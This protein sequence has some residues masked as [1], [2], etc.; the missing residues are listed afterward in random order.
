M[1]HAPDKQLMP[2]H[3][4]ALASL[5]QPST[6]SSHAHAQQVL[7]TTDFRLAQLARHGR[8]N[9]QAKQPQTA[10]SCQVQLP[11]EVAVPKHPIAQGS[12]RI[13][14][15]C[16]CAQDTLCCGLGLA[17]GL[18]MLRDAT[19]LVHASVL[20][21]EPGLVPRLPSQVHDKEAAKPGKCEPHSQPRRGGSPLGEG[22]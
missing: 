17:A 1:R 7:V 13:M 16:C 19:E 2:D 22:L 15:L 5:K 10:A 20:L 6:Q 12:C 3:S 21:N 14:R 11:R 8:T 4:A 9:V 18:L